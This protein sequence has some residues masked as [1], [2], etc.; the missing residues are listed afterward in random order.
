MLAP[1]KLYSELIIKVS[2]PSCAPPSPPHTLNTAV[3][4]SGFLRLD[5]NKEGDRVRGETARS[6]SLMP[7]VDGCF[8]LVLRGSKNLLN[9]QQLCPLRHIRGHHPVSWSSDILLL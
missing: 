9:W 8:C 2:F 3:G 7:S 5:Q 6:G 4:G 1:V